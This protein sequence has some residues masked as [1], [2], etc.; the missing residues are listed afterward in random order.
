[1]AGKIPKSLGKPGDFH[2]NPVHHDDIATAITESLNNWV[3]V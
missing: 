2:Y 3:K 1:M